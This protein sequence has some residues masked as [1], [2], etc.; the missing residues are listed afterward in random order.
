MKLGITDSEKRLLFIVLA[1]ALLVCTYFFVFTK[2]MDQAAAIE[3][4][5]VQ[6][7]ATVDQLQ[8]MVDLQAETQKETEGYKQ[9]IK[10]IIA[11][12]PV[13]IPQEKSIYLVQSMQDEIGVYIP[14]ISFSMDN[15]VMTFSGDE[16]VSGRSAN[17]AMA[18]TCTYDQFKELLKYVTEQKDRV[19]IPSI[20][21]AFDQAT[22]LITGSMTYK[23]YFLTNTGKEYEE[24][25]E[26]GLEK[27][28]PSIFYGSDVTWEDLVNFFNGWLTDQ[29]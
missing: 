6:D 24:F 18:Y 5:N 12:Y 29:D 14:S 21:A 9:T 25:P 19:T 2:F 7:Q 26:T 13:K 1:L 27:G 20:S 3:A 4:S 8:S 22:G 23:M 17:L 15:L 11:K 10:D 16:G 28:V